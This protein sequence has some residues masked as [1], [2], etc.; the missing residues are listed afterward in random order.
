MFD[1]DALPL[2]A[3]RGSR[4][5]SCVSDTKPVLL[6]S[7]VHY[8]AAPP[9]HERAFLDWLD[10]AAAEASAIIING[11]LFDFWFECRTGV[12]R[13]YDELLGKLREIV[14]GG[15]PL[16]PF[17]AAA[18]QYYLPVYLIWTLQNL[19]SVEYA[20]ESA[21]LA[22]DPGTEREMLHDFRK[23]KFALF[24][25]PQVAAVKRL[26]WRVAEHPDLGEFADT[27]LVNYW[28]DAA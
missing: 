15:V 25:K 13:G 19:D 24:T 22:L 11:D 2:P 23:S 1:M 8:G 20:T 21:L 10:F 27:A 4:L 28:I 17:S 16:T 9:E 18:F 3:R 14:A 12:T 7:D 5:P 26:L 6:A